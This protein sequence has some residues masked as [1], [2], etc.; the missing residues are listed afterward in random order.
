LTASLCR[1]LYSRVR[2]TLSLFQSAV[3]CSLQ[4]GGAGLSDRRD[5]VLSG[6]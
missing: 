3:I 2:A 5:K 4:G 6:T 1:F